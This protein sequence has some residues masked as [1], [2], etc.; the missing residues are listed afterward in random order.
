MSSAACRSTNSPARSFTRPLPLVV[1]TPT[2]GH[3]GSIPLSLISQRSPANQR[4]HV[5]ARLA[6]FRARL[7][8]HRRG[9]QGRGQAA[10]KPATGDPEQRQ[11][12]VKQGTQI[13]IQTT[14]NNTISVQYVDAVLK[15]QVTPQITADG[16]VFMDVLVENTQ[17]D[18]GIP[19]GQRRPGTGHP[20][21]ADQG[22]DRRWRHGGDR[23]RDGQPAADQTNS[24]CRC[25]AASR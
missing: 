4:L 12:I 5:L 7:P 1:G 10:L 18:N 8:D 25:S 15:L 24:R 22:A 19:L 21:R 14:I 11:A 23:R 6:E 9:I 13:P 3:V 17:I 20:V 16:T 2:A